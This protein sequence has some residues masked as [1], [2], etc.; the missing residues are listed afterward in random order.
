MELQAL[1]TDTDVDLPTEYQELQGVVREFANEVVAPVSARHGS[2]RYR[3]P[4]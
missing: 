4:A 1:I 2:R 3:E